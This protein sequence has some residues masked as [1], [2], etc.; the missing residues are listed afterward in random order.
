MTG[1]QGE[2]DVTH[3][4]IRKPQLGS[5]VRFGPGCRTIEEEEAMG[6]RRVRLSIAADFLPVS[7]NLP[8]FRPNNR[9]Y[10]DRLWFTSSDDISTRRTRLKPRERIYIT[11]TE[12]RSDRT[13]EEIVP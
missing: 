5:H 8:D 4:L 13:S 9:R 2:L 6:M 3:L 11:V 10:A 7:E 12:R 1:E